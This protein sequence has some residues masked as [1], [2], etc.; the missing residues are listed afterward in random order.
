LEEVDFEDL[1]LDEGD[2]MSFR[3]EYGFKDKTRKEIK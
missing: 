3:I 1:M 2:K